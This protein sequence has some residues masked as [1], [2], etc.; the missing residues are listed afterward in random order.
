M[1]VI[2]KAL[3]ATEPTDDQVSIDEAMVVVLFGAVLSDGLVGIEEATRIDD[4]VAASPL[5]WRREAAATK[6]MGARAAS[7]FAQRGTEA[8]LAM[9]AEAIP[10]ALHATAFALAV[11]L[12]LVDGQ[13]GPW[14][15]AY[16][17]NLQRAFNIDDVV[18]L[19]IVEVLLIKNRTWRSNGNR[20]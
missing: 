7:L 5:R 8:V 2:E 15:H 16:I 20:C 18:A 10:H 1:S 3:L 17:D 6:V 4:I 13:V 14:E 11:D 19:R 9:C 12:M